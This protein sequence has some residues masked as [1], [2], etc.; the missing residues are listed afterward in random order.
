MT[1]EQTLKDMTDN[2]LGLNA[3]IEELKAMIKE[4]E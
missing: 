4:L 3:L 1:R 2:L